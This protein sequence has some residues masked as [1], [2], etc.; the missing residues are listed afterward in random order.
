MRRP[1]KIDLAPYDREG[2]W[3]E[4]A[5]PRWLTPRESGVIKDI[6]AGEGQVRALVLAWHVID[7]TGLALS[8]PAS[9]PLDDLPNG[10]IAIIVSDFSQLAAQPLPKASSRP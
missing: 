6:P 7:D 10:L 9:D 4:I 3:I 8:D 5:D 1:Y 2:Q